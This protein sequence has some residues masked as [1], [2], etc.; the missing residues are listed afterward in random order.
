MKLLILGLVAAALASAQ[1]GLSVNITPGPPQRAY[2]IVYGYS[3][4]NLSYICYAPSVVTTGT[5]AVRTTSISAASNAS[6]VSL[7][8]TAHGFDANSRPS[9]TISGGTGNWTAING[10][11]VATITGA[12]T[13][14]I[15]VDSTAF[16]ALAGTIVFT[17][18]A[19][20]TNQTDWAVE[21]YFYDGSNNPIL[22]V[23]LGGSSGIVGVKC[24][25][26]T[27]TTNNI[28]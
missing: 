11:F 27:S 19:P 22:A 13:F 20:R 25:D 5:R 28:Q 7:T 26:A 12:N 9:V 21:R 23:W 6:P 14:T 15:P 24:S 8:S 10:T 18:T 17:S 4:T 16:G 2:Q 3:G 1:D